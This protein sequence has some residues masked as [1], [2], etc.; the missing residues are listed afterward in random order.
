MVTSIVRQGSG[1]TGPKRGGAETCH[2]EAKT[3]S[4]PV[5]CITLRVCRCTRQRWTGVWCIPFIPSSPQTVR[6]TSVPGG[7]CQ[8]QSFRNARISLQVWLGQAKMGCRKMKSEERSTESASLAS[9][10]DIPFSVFPCLLTGRPL[11]ATTISPTNIGGVQRVA[12]P[13]FRTAETKSLLSLAPCH[14]APSCASVG[15]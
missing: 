5:S 1:D 13:P 7:P 9:R 10:K 12:G 8:I 11:K 4:K 14:F 2:F 15:M 3:D 6:C